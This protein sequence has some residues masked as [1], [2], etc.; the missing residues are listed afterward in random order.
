MQWLKWHYRIISEG[1]FSERL[2]VIQTCKIPIP[3]VLLIWKLDKV[4]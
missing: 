3:E 4:C 1:L 2:Q